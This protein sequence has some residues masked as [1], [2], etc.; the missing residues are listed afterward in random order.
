MK[1]SSDPDLSRYGNHYTAEQVI[2]LFAPEEATV[3]IVRSWIIESG[4]QKDRIS[5]S[6][7]KAW[8]QFDATTEEME[9]LLQTKY[10]YY[11][12]VSGGL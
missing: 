1:S 2:N 7:N 9:R 5:Q 3:E 10:Q 11:E 12:Y 4:I 6:T 8:L